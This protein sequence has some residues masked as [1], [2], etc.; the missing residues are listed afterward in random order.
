MSAA[1]W[2][3]VRRWRHEPYGHM[4]QG[5]A[6]PGTRYINEDLL[7]FYSAHLKLYKTA[8]KAALVM[9]AW[10]RR[11]DLSRIR[12]FDPQFLPAACANDVFQSADRDEYQFAE[13]QSQ[14]W[15]ERVDRPVASQAASI[16]ET[17]RPSGAARY[18]AVN[19]YR[20]GTPTSTTAG[21]PHV[22]LTG[23]REPTFYEMGRSP[24]LYKT[25][26]NAARE[27]NGADARRIG[28]ELLQIQ[29]TQGSFERRAAMNQTWVERLRWLDAF[30]GVVLLW[31]PSLM[32]MAYWCHQQLS[33]DEYASYQ[34]QI[35]AQRAHMLQAQHR[36]LATGN[37]TD[38]S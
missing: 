36:S 32:P 7:P 19:P 25:L 2:E 31:D 6:S 38:A 37:Q 18:L 13:R 14:L 5:D 21:I 34:E 24:T 4:F 8:R 16:A 9:K 26:R 20:Y 17:A 3:R 29:V 27:A 22:L 33:R 1:I 10:N 11:T 35:W 28:G 15:A 12:R 23:D 30:P